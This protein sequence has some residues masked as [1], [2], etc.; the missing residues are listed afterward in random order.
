MELLRDLFVASIAGGVAGLSGED[1]LAESLRNIPISSDNKI[2]EFRPRLA[3]E[4]SSVLRQAAL[5]G[6]V[7]VD[8][9]HVAHGESVIEIR[10]PK[11]V[12]LAKVEHD[13][14]MGI[15][16]ERVE[17]ELV[18]LL[19]R[20]VGRPVF[21]V[22][23]R[24]V[25]ASHLAKHLLA[26]YPELLKEEQVYTLAGGLSANPEVFVEMLKSRKEIRQEHRQEVRQEDWK[27]KAFTGN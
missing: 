18:E 17:K 26:T 14:D 9:R 1:A 20:S 13:K 2:E 12:K 15:I 10:A 16:D 27:A 5:E 21:F 23:M 22:C 11:G 3:E 4:F 6:A 25:R 19:K 24:N 8:A 7:L